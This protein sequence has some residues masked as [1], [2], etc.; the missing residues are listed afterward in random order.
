MSLI[1]VEEELE[2]AEREVK[3]LRTKLEELET[4]MQEKPPSSSLSK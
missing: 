4:Q 3:V 2:K 1:G